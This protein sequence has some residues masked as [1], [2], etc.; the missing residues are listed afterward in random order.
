MNFFK[1]LSFIRSFHYYPSNF[2]EKTS[3]HWTENLSAHVYLQQI[4]NGKWQSW[5]CDSKMTKV[6]FSPS[7]GFDPVPLEPKASVLPMCLTF[8]HKTKVA[9]YQEHLT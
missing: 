2:K 9:H 1:V 6:E 3:N 7:P 4:F 5:D 8:K